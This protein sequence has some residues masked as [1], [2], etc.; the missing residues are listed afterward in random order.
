MKTCI[1]D[2]FLGSL[3][4]PKIPTCSRACVNAVSLAVAAKISAFQ[5]G[6]NNIF[7]NQV[8]LFGRLSCVDTVRVADI[9]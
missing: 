6:E 4:I 3:E 2:T 5:K 7:L 1:S 9:Q 8:G